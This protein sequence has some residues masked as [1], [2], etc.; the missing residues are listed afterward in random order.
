MKVLEIKATEGPNYWS[1]RRQ[2]LIVML[3]DLEELEEKPTNQIPHFYDRIKEMLPTLWQHHCSED[4]EGG[5]FERVKHGTWMG[6]V[7]EHIALELQVLAGL[8]ADFGRT[9]G[10]GE[11]GKY[12]VVF[13]YE[14]QESGRYS[15]EAAVRI[16]GALVSGQQ[17]DINSEI[18]T[19]RAIAA[20]N[21]L[22]PSTASIVDEAKSRNIPVIRLD[23]DSLIQLGYG[24]AQRRIEA[25]IASTTCGIA[26]GLASCKNAT[27]KLLSANYI[28]V[29]EGQK[30]STETELKMICESLGYPL[31][32]KPVDGNQGKGAT[33]NIRNYDEALAAFRLA[34]DF[35]NYLIGEK[36]ISGVDF[37]VLII[38]FK[39]EAAAL[40]TPAR[41]T[42]DGVHTIA[43]L[44][45]M[46]NEDPRRGDDHENELTKI[47]LDEITVNFLK[48]QHLAPD[49][50]VPRRKEVLLRPT[51][52]LSTGGT[53]TDVTDQIHPANIKL[54]ER[55]ARIM[56]LNICGIDV[57]A[58]SIAEPIT[59]N[60]GAIIE[61]NA[62][63]GFRMH[64][65]PTVGKARNVAKPVIDMMFPGNGNG[66]IP[67]MAV[68]GT[69]GKTTT[70]RLLAHIAKH[71]GYHVGYTTTDGIYIDDEMILEGDCTGPV[72]TRTVLHDSWVDMAILEC[73]R[74]GILRGGLGFDQCDVGIITNIAGDHLGLGGIDTMEQLAKVKSTV[75]ESVKPDGYAILNAD[76][77]MVYALRE[78]LK[79]RIAL[80]SMNS[81]CPRLREHVAK[82]G[83]AAIY[84]N[85]FITILEGKMLFRIGRASQLPITFG[86]AASFN[87]ANVLAAVLAAF[88]QKIHPR[89]ILEALMGFIPGPETI[90]GRMNV[91]EFPDHKV[92]VDYAHNPH[93]VESIAEF[94]RSMPA[95]RK[96]G[97]ITGVGDR[98]S[99]DIT[100]L[101]YEAAKIFDEIV[102]RHDEDMRGR[103]IAELDQL[104]TDG[105]KQLDPEK[106]ITI[107]DTEIHAV[108]EVLNNH[109]SGSISV[110]FA[111][112]IKAVVDEVRKAYIKKP[113]QVLEMA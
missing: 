86:G 33:T 49:A 44:I 89:D 15:A 75:V 106:K 72:S 28:P 69:N 55:V 46:E 63:P 50:I 23:E 108:Q 7:I 4:M 97:V 17:Y 82:G 38:N 54:F 100:A 53:A 91:F 22:G 59:E 19:I 67:I 105:I 87:I 35:S 60:G 16:A 73:A 1:I 85:N 74:G 52:N 36:F 64:L 6:H 94:L 71:A 109:T 58:P 104:L 26:V 83:L 41:V 21:R 18:G 93:G 5:F 51:A 66:R 65:N 3:L 107:V 80:F 2:Q 8:K 79:C 77:P 14:D 11:P 42:G 111:D 9:R 95:S 43:E 37:R 68:T 113:G 29:P 102:I 10:A 30:F 110:I 78:K 20:R 57:M 31:V 45:Q 92:I 39:F 90:P 25:T 12:Y 47:K 84:E 27:K 34:K 56:N 40:R 32:I 62:A 70:T 76:D 96:I 112:N 103:D 61:V 101:A 48:Q 99:E 24:A 98:R 13:D 88:I 81:D